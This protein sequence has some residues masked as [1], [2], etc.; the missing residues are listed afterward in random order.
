MCT[1][2]T[3]NLIK[4]YYPVLKKSVYFKY[5]KT[6]MFILSQAVKTHAP[7]TDFILRSAVF[8]KYLALITT[9]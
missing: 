9:G 1:N 3:M 4:K 7:P 6:Y 2:C 5:L 8:E